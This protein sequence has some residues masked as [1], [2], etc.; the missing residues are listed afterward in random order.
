MSACVQVF[1]A[2]RRGH[3]T[4]RAICAA[5][6]LAYVQACSAL[7]GLAERHLIVCGGMGPGAMWVIVPGAVE[8]E[9]VGRIGGKAHHAKSRPVARRVVAPCALASAM[10]YA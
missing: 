4:N 8:P 2:I 9:S 1:R 10:G 7:R 3:R 5:T 6:G